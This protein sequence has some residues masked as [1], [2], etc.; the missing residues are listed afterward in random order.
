MRREG[1]LL[2]F[3]NV[4]IKGSIDSHSAGMRM[5]EA[6]VKKSLVGDLALREGGWESLNNRVYRVKNSPKSFLM[7]QWPSE[8][9][10]LVFN[11]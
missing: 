1:S 8:M 2:Y 4:S 5:A 7:P 6:K 9:G 3:Q 11:I 10:V